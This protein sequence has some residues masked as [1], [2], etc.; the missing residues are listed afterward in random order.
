MALG[1]SS[2]S[3]SGATQDPIA[4]INGFLNKTFG[5]PLAPKPTTPQMNVAPQQSQPQM[6]M[7]PKQGSNPGMIKST[8][9]PQG[10]VTNYDTKPNPSVLAQQ[11]ALNKL[12]A[13]LVEDGIIGD[14]TRAA[15]AK[16]GNSSGSSTPAAQPQQDVQPQYYD[17]NSGKLTDLGKSMGLTD[18]NGPAPVVEKPPAPLTVAG[19][20][21]GLL[22]AGQQTQNESATQKQLEETGAQTAWEQ[23]IQSGKSVEEAN[24]VLTDLRMK[25]AEKYAQVDTTP[26]PLEFQTGR[27]A[28]MGRQFASQEAAAQQGVGNALQNQSQQI[29]LAQTQAAREQAARQAAYLGAQTQAGRGLSAQ[30]GALGAV[31][32]QFPS[33]GS[34]IIQPGLLGSNGGVSGANLQQDVASVVQRLQNGTM[35]YNDALAALSGYGQGGVSALQQALPPGFNITQS[36]TLATQ[37]GSVGVNYQLAETALS[38]VENVLQTL[39]AAQKTNI[40]LLTKGANWISTQF[41]IGS[42]Q[43]REMVGAVQ[44]L[45]NAY[46][47][48][49][50]SV[51]GG[52]PTDYSSQAIA[53]IPNEPTPNDIAAVRKNFE[54]LGQARKNILGNPGNAGNAGG[55]TSGGFAETW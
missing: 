29:T 2:F 53:E 21:P 31:A 42:K 7:A 44:S 25:I 46:A 30:Q 39:G 47:S 48:L 43:T 27:K 1:N 34:Q 26:I 3:Q 22:G 5:I 23:A 18:V 16:Y 36:N 15:I 45:R 10:T 14:K 24:K 11:K 35:S 20:V 52:T 13:G 50:A 37:Q 38:N 8:T 17:K 54:V 6:S 19:Q 12:G 51:K 41:G 32:P 55:S 49:L 33:Y 4:G 9:S 28:A 40:P